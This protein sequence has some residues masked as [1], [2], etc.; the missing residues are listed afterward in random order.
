MVSTSSRIERRGSQLVIWVQPFSS[1]VCVSLAYFSKTLPNYNI[2]MIKQALQN[3]TVFFQSC[4]N[5]SPQFSNTYSVSLK[6]K[7]LQHSGKHTPIVFY[8]SHQILNL[9]IFS[10][11]CFFFFVLPVIDIYTQGHKVAAFF[12]AL[13]LGGQRAKTVGI[14]SYLKEFAFM[15]NVLNMCLTLSGAF[16]SKE[17]APSIQP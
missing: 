10:L 11:C 16:M 9:N 12:N 7:V 5:R 6:E 15:C 3:W 14:I 2:K 13:I 8:S 1:I 4:T 17:G